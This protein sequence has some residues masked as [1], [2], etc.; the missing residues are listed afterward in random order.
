[1]KE[2]EM[3][4]FFVIFFFIIMIKCNFDVYLVIVLISLFKNGLFVIFV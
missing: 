3:W 4:K 1:M 2:L